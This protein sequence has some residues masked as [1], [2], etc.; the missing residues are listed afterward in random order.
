[1]L[2]VMFGCEKFHKLLWQNDVTI[3]SDHKPLETVM[4]KPISSAPM[5]F[6]K[7]KLTKSLWLADC[8]SRLP[9]PS[10]VSQ[11]MMKWWFS[12]LIHWQ[13]TSMKATILNN[14]LQMLKN[15]FNSVRW[16]DRR[17][18]AP[19]EVLQFLDFRDELSTNNVVF[20]HGEL[21]VIP[22]GLRSSTLKN[23]WQLT[24]GNLEVLATCKGTSLLARNE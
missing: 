15:V 3:E 9:L 19:L 20:Y 11:L 17:A 10:L 24:H 7:M 16:P 8:L 12:K 5:R 22:F 4:R 18:D 21:I 6:Q 13:T 14:Q 23:Y 2:A 1:M